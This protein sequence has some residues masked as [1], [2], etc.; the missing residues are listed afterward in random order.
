MTNF[1]NIIKVSALTLIVCLLAACD[2][3][4]DSQLLISNAQKAVPSD[5]HLA[6]I[7]QRSCRVCHATDE[8]TAPLVGDEKAWKPRMEKG[9][10]ELLN[11]VVNGFGGMPPF[12][13]CMDCNA[14]EFEQLIEFMA[15][16]KS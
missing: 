16:A 5:N 10:D 2:N 6:Q 15:K 4:V 1:L 8:S 3:S 7:Y 13:M 11:N 12:G 14:D 9:M